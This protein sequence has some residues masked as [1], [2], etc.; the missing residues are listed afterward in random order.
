MTHHDTTA[1]IIIVG[2]GIIGVAIAYYL[3]QRQFGRILVLERLHIGAGSTGLSVASIEPLGRFPCLAA[4]HQRSIATFQ[5]FSAEVSGECGFVPLPLAMFISEKEVP[6]LREIADYAGA[7]GSDA[8][9][10]AP[11]E[12][13]ARNPDTNMEGVA[14]VYYSEDAGHA[15]PI[16]TLTSY[17]EAAR[18]KGVVIQQNTPVLGVRSPNGHIVGVDTPDG[19]ISAPIVVLAAGLWIEPLLKPLGL[20]AAIDLHRHFVVGIEPP[21]HAPRLSIID[22][23]LDFYSR[24][25]KSG[26]VYL[27]G[28][29]GE[30]APCRDPDEHAPSV[31]MD[32]SFKYMERLVERFPIMEQSRLR[33]NSGYTGIADMTPDRQPLLGPLPV[34]GLY[35]AA[36][37]SGIG[38]KMAPGI[39]QAMAGLIAGESAAQRLLQPLRPTRIAEG[40]LLASP[41]TTMIL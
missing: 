12:F 2:G 28:G 33:A 27:L 19:L 5:N 8:H 9:L 38:F 29:P 6:T 22:T 17:A 39:G 15:D 10:L 1:D 16:L 23:V 11:D 34:E 35:L 37:M 18:H 32:L 3:A 14:A 41:Y 24:P 30:F 26:Q 13:L 7:A 25:E 40:Q 36:G 20:T 21:L 4:I 31:S